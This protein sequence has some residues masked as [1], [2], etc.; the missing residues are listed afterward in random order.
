MSKNGDTLNDSHAEVMCRRGFLRYLYEQIDHSIAKRESIFSF[1]EC[2]KTFK[3]SEKC[4]FHFFTTHAPCGD[5]SIYSTEIDHSEPEVKRAK[6]ETNINE[7]SVGE[8]ISTTVTNFTG[9]KIIYKNTDV[10]SDLMLQSIGEIRTK[11][12]RGQPTLSISC[13]DKIAKWNVLGVQG[14]LIYSLL[15][16]PIYLM[17]VT[18][19][20]RKF[21]NAEATE[22]AI[23]K[24]F[25]DK[26]NFTSDL[27][28]IIKPTIQI[29][30]DIPFK[31]E[32]CDKRE[33]APGSIVWSKV[34]KHPHQVAV[35]GKRLGVTK[36]KANSLSGRLLISKIELFRCYVNILR[37]LNTNLGIF[38]KDIDLDNLQ[39]SDAKNASI[40]YQRAWTDLKETYFRI[41]STKPK[42]L[43]SFHID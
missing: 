30:T 18:I 2:T 35:N 7:D 3:I 29:C 28:A 33:P 41:W 16:K 4:S 39:Y 26:H 43:N 9:A 34:T 5:A 42:G 36:K 21:S 22:R 17:S 40:E 6:I 38:P 37:I 12:G 20:N 10:A 25:E 15:R 24:R 31:Y 32:K 13:S 11:P 1:N 23:W 8:C 14:A 27:F 19:C